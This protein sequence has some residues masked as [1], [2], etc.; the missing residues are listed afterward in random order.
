MDLPP[1]T[2]KTLRQTRLS[3]SMQGFPATFSIDGRQYVAV[4]TGLGGGSPRNV[5]RTIFPDIH[6]PTTGN[7]LYI[8]ALPEK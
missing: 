7:A 6:H 8:F 1:N 4:S 3:T 5:P 2:G